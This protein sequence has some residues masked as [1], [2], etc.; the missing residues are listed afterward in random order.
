MPSFSRERK[1]DGHVAGIDEAGRGPLAGPV[2]AAA[3]ILDPARLPRGVDDSKAM[4]AE[5]RDKA[6]DK[7]MERA[8]AVGIG[9]ASVAEIDEINILQA[10]MLA[11]RRATEALAIAPAQA[12]VDGNR[13]PTLPC[14]VETIIDG[15]AKSMSIAAASIIAK[16]TRDR[17]M[18]ALD[19]EHPYYQWAQNKGYGTA[20]HLVALGL[21]GPTVHHRQ[22]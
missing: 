2:Y 5:A 14:P 20:D 12:F 6:F 21:L 13:A 3:V 17:V 16:V 18:R 9:V 10:T 1:I 19:S 7:I 11:M 22:S 4:T 15:D 8:L